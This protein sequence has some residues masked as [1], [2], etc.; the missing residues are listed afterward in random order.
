MALR[1]KKEKYDREHDAEL[2]K[3]KAANRL[4][5]ANVTDM[6]EIP[7]KQWR[8][9]YAG[10]AAEVNDLSASLS[11]PKAELAEMDKIRK[12]IDRVLK[13]QAHEQ[14]I[15]EQKDKKPEQNI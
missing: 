11:A 9:E 7:V 5:H 13:E 12:M 8:A 15:A 3:W 10:L 14:E 2:I 4:L 1:A 6:K